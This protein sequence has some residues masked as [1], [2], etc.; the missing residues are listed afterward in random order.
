MAMILASRIDE[1]AEVTLGLDIGTNTEIILAQNGELTSCSCASGPAF[2]GAHIHQGMSAVAGAISR[3]WLTEGGSKVFYETIG[4]QPP[5]GICGSGV[6][7]GVAELS[8]QGVIS[9]SGRFDQ[10]HPRVRA[11]KENGIAEYLLVPAAESGTG[12]DLVL[13]QQDIREIQLAKAAIATGIKILLGAAGLQETDLQRVVLAGAFGTHLDPESAVAIGMLPDLPRERFHQVGNAAGT[14]ARMILL[15][16]KERRRAEKIAR[17][18]K[19]L[20]LTTVK[21]FNDT[22]LA[23]LAFPGRHSA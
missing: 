21:G 4:G 19:Y 14:G 17:Q 23:E 5:L 22:F 7:D 16:L 9:E 3:V 2:E 15:S 10:S 1:M 11:G 18:V 13:T 6:L 20:E 12:Y 8:R